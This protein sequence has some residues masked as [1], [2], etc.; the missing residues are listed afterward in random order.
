MR[1]H[2]MRGASERRHR[3]DRWGFESAVE[4]TLGWL[5]RSALAL[6]RRRRWARISGYAVA[7]AL[8]VVAGT[9]AYRHAQMQI[10]NRHEL[11]PVGPGAFELSPQGR[12]FYVYAPK[13]LEIWSVRERRRVALI[14]N[15]DEKLTW[16]A[17]SPDGRLLAGYIHRGTYLHG[18]SEDV[19][20]TRVKDASTEK[21]LEA[22][23]GISDPEWSPDGSLL[24]TAGPE[25]IRVWRVRDGKQLRAFEDHGVPLGALGAV[26]WSPDGRVL[27][28]EGEEHE[29]GLW[30]VKSGRRLRTLPKDR[31]SGYGVTAFSPDG[32]LFARGGETVELWS[33]AEGRLVRKLEGPGSTASALAFSPDGDV[34][35]TGTAEG[36]IRLW[37]LS[38]GKLLSTYYAYGPVDAVAFT[39]G[40]REIVAHGEDETVRIWSVEDDR[41]EV[42]S[43]GSG[44]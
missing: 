33:V 16:P 22:G 19:R 29:V 14:R 35:A 39:P 28:T 27:A 37:S 9:Q 31:G 6:W 21:I 23:R 7:V 32:R 5:A 3:D 1:P 41:L 2:E 42:E 24:A 13:G 8:T 25:A 40:A 4:R 15:A 43:A 20:L 30:D 36:E 18:E 12:Y 10:Q 11:I 38:G 17:L 34:L 44:S 26:R